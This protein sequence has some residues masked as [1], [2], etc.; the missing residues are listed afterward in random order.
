FLEEDWLYEAITETYI[1][2]L[3]VFDGLER[4]GVDWRMT[5][6]VTPT[7]AAMLSDPL[8]QY[9]Y[10]RNI[11]NL[12]ALAGKEVERTR[13]QPEFNHLAQM[14]HYRFTRAR[15]VFVKQYG[16]NLING[17]RRFFDTGKLEIITCGATHGFLP[18]MT[19]NRNA[20]RAQVEIGAREF[21]RHFGR[22]PQGIWLP[23]CG[24]SP[25]IDE[26]LRDAGIRYFFTDTHGVL[27]AEPRPRYGVF[28]P[29]L[30]PNTNVAA[31]A[32]DTES[33]KQVWSA[34]EGYPGDFH[35]RDFYRDVGFDLDFEYL[36][37]HLHQ[38]GIRSHLG[39]K[40]YKITG[41]T[42]NKQ[43]YDPRAALDKA[44]EHAGNFM[45]N[46]EKQVEW[47]AGSLD[48]RP[49]LIVAPYDA[50]L[51]GHWWFEGPDWI[52]F[53]MR[54]MHFDQQTVKTI[55]VPEYL[56]RHPKL[57]TAQPTLS[58][59]GYK[60]Y[61][62]VWLEGSNDWIYRHLHE[63]ADRM[64]EL[65]RSYGSPTQVQRRALNQAARELLLAQS[66]DWAFI[67]KTGTM[68]DYARER[69]RLHVV[70]LNHLY[71]QIKGNDI[72][73]PWLTE[74]ERRHNLFPDLDYR[75]YA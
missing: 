31:L 27:F 8:L 62:E 7:L 63:G 73:E 35:Y 5:M 67:L 60:G 29:I 74:I 54:K 65:A 41:R 39:I 61:C 52:N 70:N 43:P 53:L 34:I 68:A 69:T 56:D 28:A 17:F 22:R 51:F 12:I 36:K 13:W 1:P 3:E 14:Y 9:R 15:D 55:T 38:S 44:A 72:D 66:S 59:W 26:P 45:F 10:V 48:G 20:V 47:L 37:P 19:I 50:E 23:E 40:Y 4:D 32:R 42:D 18:L 30:C 6:T 33:S 71:E 21:A 2:I 25:D 24:Y 64:V 49:P 46:R 58:S 11:D 75:V 16:N 57:Q